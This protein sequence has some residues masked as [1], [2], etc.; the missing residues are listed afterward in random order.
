MNTCIQRINKYLSDTGITLTELHHETLI[1]LQA[2]QDIMSGA[3]QPTYMQC[4]VIVNKICKRYPVSEH[5]NIYH[6]IIVKPIFE[7][8]TQ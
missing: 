8:K 2:L 3:K 1:P 7:D 4:M 5:W 6:D